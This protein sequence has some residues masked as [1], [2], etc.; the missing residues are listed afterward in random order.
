VVNVE[1][2]FT[3][4]FSCNRL[5][6]I[7]PIS[8][9]FRLFDVTGNSVANLPDSLFEVRSRISLTGNP[10]S[11]AFNNT[12]PELAAIE[13]IDIV[14]TDI[15]IA[16]FGRAMQELMSTFHCD[17]LSDARLLHFDAGASVVYAE[18]IGLRQTM[19]DTIIVKQHYCGHTTSTVCSTATAANVSPAMLRT[20]F[21]P[22]LP[23]N[24]RHRPLY[25]TLSS[26]FTRG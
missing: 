21:P 4:D 25:W 18:M 16:S 12:S 5:S 22:F 6:S 2:P 9:F 20:V 17:E 26:S 11:P 13:E 7:P 14:R 10:I 3:F 15:R 24:R 19:E 1:S 8:A 23:I